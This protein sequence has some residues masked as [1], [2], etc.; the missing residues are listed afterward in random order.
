[1]PIATRLTERRGVRHPIMLAPMGVVSDGRLVATVS[2]AG[3]RKRPWP[4]SPLLP[5]C[6]FHRQ[7][8]GVGGRRQR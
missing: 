5:G 6:D 2:R 1:M 7:A 3:R 8:A 4:Y